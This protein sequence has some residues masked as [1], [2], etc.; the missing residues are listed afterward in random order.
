MPYRTDT[1]LRP[2]LTLHENLRGVYCIESRNLAPAPI[3]TKCV[4]ST[5]FITHE[6]IVASARRYIATI[7]ILQRRNIAIAIGAPG[8][9]QARK[10]KSQKIRKVEG[11]ILYGMDV[12]A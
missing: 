5:I 3:A 8:P 2:A 10:E 6:R 9:W 1:I 4:A 11:R 12:P 7:A